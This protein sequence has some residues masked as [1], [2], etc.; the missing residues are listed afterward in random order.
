[1]TLATCERL[2]KHFETIGNKADAEVMRQ[3]VAL[4][5]GAVVT[6]NKSK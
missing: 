4:K 1:M 5:G 2:L 6:K 3:R